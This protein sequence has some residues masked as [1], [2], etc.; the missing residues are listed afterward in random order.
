MKNKSAYKILLE[1]HLFL[2]LAVFTLPFASKIYG[3]LIPFF[4][5]VLLLNTKNK[6]NE[7]LL[8]AV[9]VAASEVFYE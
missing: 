9:Y 1:L 3:L 6:N 2:A 8:V 4:G 7:A 5:T